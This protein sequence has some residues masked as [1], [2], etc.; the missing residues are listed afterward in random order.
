[1]FSAADEYL[2]FQKGHGLF[3]HGILA[4][5]EEEFP[6]HKRCR[7]RNSLGMGRRGALAE[8]SSVDEVRR[9]AG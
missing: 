9:A 8:A 6:R 2:C 3:E 5:L 4:I 7:S 1:L